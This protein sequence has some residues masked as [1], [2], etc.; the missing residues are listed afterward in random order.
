MKTIVLQLTFAII[1]LGLLLSQNELHAQGGV[2]YYSYTKL[3]E[4]KPDMSGGFESIVVSLKLEILSHAELKTGLGFVQTYFGEGIRD[5]APV[6]WV[7]SRTDGQVQYFKTSSPVQG[8]ASVALFEEELKFE[9]NEEI[10]FPLEIRLNR[11]DKELEYR[12]ALSDKSLEDG[13]QAVG[14]VARPL[15]SAGNEMPTFAV[16]SLEDGQDINLEDYRGKTLVIN[17][18]ATF[19]GPCLKEMPN[20][21]ALESKFENDPNVVFLAIAWDKK[22]A[23]QKFL[24]KRDFKYTQSLYGADTFSLFGNA[25]PLHVVVDPFGKI[26]FFRAGYDPLIDAEI[27]EAILALTES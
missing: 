12:W 25:F 7:A 13:G 21:N 24:S 8:D 2:P 18:W 16:R 5:G 20:L 19:C 22:E 3:N 1:A 27:E 26:A 11:F 9:A 15:L 6:F 23:V 4:S 17:W 10:I 14:T